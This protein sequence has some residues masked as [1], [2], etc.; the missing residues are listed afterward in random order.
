[1]TNFSE[2]S[3][4]F[5]LQIGAINNSNSKIFGPLARSRVVRPDGGCTLNYPEKKKRDNYPTSA[6]WEERGNMAYKTLETTQRRKR[7]TV[8]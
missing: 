2:E 8:W 1:M 7:G 4:L 3:K 5:I 6:A